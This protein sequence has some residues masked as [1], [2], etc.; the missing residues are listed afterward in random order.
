VICVRFLMLVC[1]D[2][3][4]VTVPP[5]TESDVEHWVEE[6]DARGLRVTGDPLAPPG[7]ARVV[8]VRDDQ[9]EVVEG[10]YLDADA[11]VGFDLL[12]CRDMAEAIEVAS[13]HPLAKRCVLELRPVV[14]AD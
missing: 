2:S 3:A 12:D 9:P 1:R 4:P 13:A 11:L 14:S 8:R 10:P 7:D 6:M 5:A